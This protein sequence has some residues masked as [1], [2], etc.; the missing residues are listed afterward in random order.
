MGGNAARLWVVFVSL[1]LLISLTAPAAAGGNGSFE[2]WLVDQSNTAGTTYGGAIHIYDGNDLM[3]TNLAGVEP[4]EVINLAG[5]TAS[6]CLA[7]TGAN[8]VRPHMVLFNVAHTHAILSFV[9]SGHVVI[10]DAATR[11]PVAC[12]RSLPGDGGL[13]QA[14]AAFPS[15]DSTYL[16]IA[17]QN[18]ERLH[19]VDIDYTTN[20]YTLSATLNL[21]VLEDPILRPNN[22]PICPIIDSTS[23]FSFVTLA[24]GGMFVVDRNLTV[25]GTY[26]NTVVH[27]NGCGGLEAG[28]SM[29]INS[30]AGA[31]IAN[32][33][34]FDVY[35][36]P[37]SGYSISNPVNSPAPT[38][39]FSDD[40]SSPD[41]DSHGMVAT[42]H[43][44]YVWVSDR[45][46]SVLEVFAVDDSSHA[47]TIVTAGGFS[48]NP[49]PDLGAVAPAGN[50]VFFSTRGP[51]PLTGSPHAAVGDSPGLM[52]IQVEQ[53]GAAG[54]VKGIVRISNMVGGVELA[55]P[56]GIAVRITG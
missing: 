35:R 36:F 14:H 11:T 10:F 26:D 34:E 22:K 45:A 19:K 5:A 51:N 31:Q 33:S 6:L 17:N 52:V 38:V 56:H 50:R 3:G 2:V 32:P 40:L 49:T 12:L 16:V 55:D 48:S 24:G 41:R 8:P 23:S 25:V 54:V 42:K 47:G 27:G 53:G 21:S 44:K 43:G 18:G 29:W 4:T 1:L 13:I 15:P 9:A 39:V 7:S 37:L 46:R 28:G 20:T 30:G